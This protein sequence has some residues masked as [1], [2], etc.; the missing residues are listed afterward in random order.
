MLALTLSFRGAAH[1]AVDDPERAAADLEEARGLLGPGQTAMLL[2]F[3]GLVALASGRLASRAGKLEEARSFFAA[4][5]SR[6]DE[7]RGW[8]A[9]TLAALVEHLGRRFVGAALPLLERALARS[10]LSQHGLPPALRR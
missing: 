8:I 10:G 5:C 2:T 1:A 3:A 6:R 4:A 9:G 7:A